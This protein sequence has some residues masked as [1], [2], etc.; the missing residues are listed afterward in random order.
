MLNRQDDLIIALQLA[1]IGAQKFFQV[2]YTR[3]PTRGHYAD[4]PSRSLAQDPKYRGFRALDYATPQGRAD[5]PR[6]M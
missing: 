6:M 3:R 1:L 5:G 4:P 2:R